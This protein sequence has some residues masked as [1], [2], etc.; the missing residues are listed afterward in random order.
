MNVPAKITLLGCLLTA[1][2]AH[3]DDRH[4]ALDSKFYASA[5]FFFADRAFKA[6][7][8]GSVDPGIP[9]TLVDFESDVN[10]DDSPQLYV[11]E[12]QWQYSEKWNLGLQYFSASR[13]EQGTLETT[14][15][16][17][18]VTY[19]VGADVRAETE[20]DI[21]RI[22]FSRESF[23]RKTDMISGWPQEFTGSTFLQESV[24]RQ[25]LTMD[26]PPSLQVQH[27]LHCPFR[28]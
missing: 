8:A 9:S 21:T 15:E 25:I 22:V 23:G 4:P 17:E 7:A 11:A 19:E 18:G 6:S 1:S 28:M 12:I 16:W 27:Q 5:G 13:D 2:L 26:R 24:A 14:V 20:I 3:A 10:V